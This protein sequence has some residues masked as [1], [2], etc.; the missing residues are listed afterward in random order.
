MP[1][2]TGKDSK[3]CFAQWGSQAKYYYTCGNEAGRKKA[4]QKAYLQ[5]AAITGGTM[6]EAEI[7]EAI[8]IFFGEINA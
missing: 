5:G 8:D 2:H 7:N 6:T 1:V 4:K 3:G